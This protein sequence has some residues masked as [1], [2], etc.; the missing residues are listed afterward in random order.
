[1]QHNFTVYRLSSGAQFVFVVKLYDYGVWRNLGWVLLC[2]CV[3]C[4]WQSWSLLRPMTMTRTRKRLVGFENSACCFSWQND[5]TTRQ[6]AWHVADTQ[7]V[8]IGN[9]ST[10]HTVNSSHRK[11]VWRVDRRVWRCC[12][13]FTVLFDLAFVPFK[14]FA[15][16]SDF[17]IARLT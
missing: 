16:V 11:I 6:G 5:L 7:P 15:V 14:S 3:S 8:F 1:M 12:D 10:R 13:E 17:D 2:G 9:K 4:W